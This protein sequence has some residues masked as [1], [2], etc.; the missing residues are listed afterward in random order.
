MKTRVALAL[1]GGGMKGFAHI[2]VIRALDELGIVPSLFAGTSIGA[3]IAAARAGGAS[4]EVMADHAIR[5]KR[6]DLFRLN[7]VGMLFERMR[8]PSI[9]QE[10]PLR[11]LIQDN[12]PPGRLDQ[13][14][15]P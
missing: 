6:R 13:L 15:V 10:E 7:H 11:Q 4:V 2:G 5:L 14:P 1:G 8:A 9:Y 3:L 12:V